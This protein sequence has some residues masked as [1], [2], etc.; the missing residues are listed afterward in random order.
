MYGRAR[1]LSPSSIAHVVR[2]DD[3]DARAFID[4]QVGRYVRAETEHE[5]QQHDHAIMRNGKTTSALALRVYSDLRPILGKTAQAAAVAAAREKLT[6]VTRELAQ[7]DQEGKL[8][9]AGI[10]QLAALAAS[11]DVEA[12]LREAADAVHR[13]DARLKA[14]VRDREA[15]ED[16]AI[17]SLR[18]EIERLEK[19]TRDYEEELKELRE[20][21][22]AY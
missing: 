15:V 1:T 20:E 3:R 8:L 16:P 22:R 12:R 10:G 7:K 11:G 2:T 19:Q 6:A 9:D 5:L 13:A 21:E 17:R 4:T 18:E 14:L